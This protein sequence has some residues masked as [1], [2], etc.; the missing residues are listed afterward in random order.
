MLVVSEEQQGRTEQ[1]SA[2]GPTV[3]GVI[4]IFLLNIVYLFSYVCYSKTSF[5]LC[6]LQENSLSHVYSS[7][8][9]F[10][11]VFLNKTFDMTNFPKKLEVSTSA[12]TTATLI[13]EKI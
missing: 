4:F 13:K 6:L 10:L 11:P 1:T 2:Q 5:H 12:M 8:T 9:S 3:C 7:K